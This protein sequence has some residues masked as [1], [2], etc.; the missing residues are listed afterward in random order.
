MVYISPNFR[1]LPAHVLFLVALV[2]C[3]N[4][5]AMASGNAADQQV[6][7]DIKSRISQDPFQIM[8]GWNDSVHYCLWEG[9]TCNSSNDRVMIINLSAKNLVGSVPQSIGN[10]TCLTA[11]NLRNNTF[12]GKIP[13]E[14]GRLLRLQQLNLT[15]NAFSGDI[16]VNL[17]YCTEL[18]VL[19]LVY[20]EL[21][22]K[23]PD[24]LSSLSKLVL[25]GL[26]GNNFT[27]S[28]PAWIGNFSSL[29]IITLALN[30]FQGRIPPELGRLS[31]LRVFQVYGNELSGTIPSS[32]YNIS[33][34]YYFSVTQN[35]LHGEL[36]PNVGLTLS[37]LEIFA[38]GVNNFT[39]QIPVSLSN[40]SKLGL[41]DFAQ[42]GLT[43]T[44][45]A[46]LGKLPN[47]FRI[48]F[49]DNTL[50]SRQSGDLDFISSLTNCTVLEVLG[51]HGNSF[52]GDLPSSIANL[53]V[54]LSILTLGS[55]FFHGKLP[56]GIGNLVNLNVLGLEENFLSDSIPDILGNFK[57][58]QGLELNDNEFSG[59]IPSSISNLTSLTRLYLQNNRLE[60]TIPPELGK[61]RSLQVLNLTGNNLT[62]AIPAEITSLSSLSISLAISRNSLS[63]SLPLEV[64]K[65][66]N[67]NELDL[68]ENKLSG[69]IPST[70]S[71]CLSLERLVLSGNLLHGTIPE[72]LKT[73]RGIV[74]MD[75]SHNNLSGEIP[76]FL[77]KLP[78]LKKLDLSFNNFVGKVPTEGVFSNASAFSLIGNEKLCGGDPGLN[79][80][81]CPEL[82][83]R[84]ATFRELKVLIPVIVSIVFLVF[85]FCGL[86][87]HFVLRRSSERPS[88]STP[89][90]VEDWERGI[91]FE[92]VFSSTN[93][94][95]ADNLIGSGS[96]GSVYEG[97][98]DEDGPIVAV[99]ILN[100]QQKG[101]SKSF[102]D[103]LRALRSIRHRNLLKI[104]AACSSI[105]PQG[106]DFKCLVFEFMSN[107]NLDQWLHP[108][109]DDQ[110]QPRSLDIV[111]RL[112]IA[113]D[114]ASAL[115]YLHN[116]CQNPIVHCDLK[117]SNILLDEN[118]TAHVGDFGL[119]TFLLEDSTLSQTISAGL[120]G[121]IGYIPP[122]YA[123]G[124]PV[125]TSGDV[126][127]YGILLL[128]L[129]TGKSPTDDIFKDGLTIHE[130]V[131]RALAGHIMMEI[132]DPYL[133]L[134]EE[135]HCKDEYESSEMKEETI[136]NNNLS[137]NSSRNLDECL[138]SVLRIGLSCSNPF[139]LNRMP[140]TI[141]VNKMQ[142]IRDLYFGIKNR[143]NEMDI[144]Y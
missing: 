27:G 134:A 7:L 126:Y 47:L 1:C 54:N 55:N 127:S 68:S 49:D 39:G 130:L 111:Q 82:A 114:I 142:E 25:F 63:G 117:P 21:V 3:M 105:D 133:L 135:K 35:Q 78:F 92:K 75:F 87:A 124:C 116:Y 136:L 59:W 6:L 70:L 41:V 71:S 37:N 67:L 64:G 91:S 123:S 57:S 108:R 129:F 85:L 56:A 110:C 45:P 102:M 98:L 62:G 76:E 28:L 109:C 36:P 20:N 125:S 79:L 93:G 66:F 16:P 26:G 31:R 119:A 143:R 73:L 107:G 77:S 48:N 104:L 115:D 103:E 106:K 58:I 122:E 95:S 97:V 4:I 40:A 120:K 32:I 34:I 60:G 86:A 96:F 17:T 2:L 51:L 33:S 61:C 10:L 118:M 38:G 5:P 90:T 101:A 131:A 141:V 84:T 128:E 138:I 80:P 88:T 9:V 18:R 42:N 8:T 23:I 15:W 53:S 139:P 24:Q 112:N 29:Q 121:S 65:L 46:V 69:E 94:F 19:D 99:K 72:S 30:S 137:Q 132:V 13:Q 14:I 44:V 113:V 144:R 52:G 22:G 100:L 89:S 140:M 81:E 74:E 11:L 50:G 83:R 43:G 12:Q